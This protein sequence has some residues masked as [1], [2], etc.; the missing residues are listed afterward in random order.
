MK[1]PEIRW[2]EADATETFLLF[3]IGV[4]LI[5]SA[6][7]GIATLILHYTFK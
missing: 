5:A 4:A 1:I 6:L 3:C 2:R 7:V